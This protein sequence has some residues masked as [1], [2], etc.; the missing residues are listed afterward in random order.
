MLDHSHY[1]KRYVITFGTAGHQGISLVLIFTLKLTCD[2]K[3]I[4]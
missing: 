2:L 3:I 4:L 1:V